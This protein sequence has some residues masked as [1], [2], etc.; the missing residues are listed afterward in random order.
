LIHSRNRPKTSDLCT[1]SGARQVRLDDPKFFDGMAGP[2]GPLARRME[3]SRAA[4]L[5]TED[6][7]K[8]L[9]L[10]GLALKAQSQAS[11]EVL[12]EGD[13]PEKTLELAL[14][15]LEYADTVFETS[16]AVDAAPLA[17]R[18]GCSWC[19]HVYVESKI[20]EVLAV[21]LAV[22]NDF[23]DEDRAA[24]RGRIEQHVKEAEGLSNEDLVGRLRHPCPLLVD[25]A[26][27]VYESRP[28]AC[29][30]WHSFDAAACKSDVEAPRSGHTMKVNGLTLALCSSLTNGCAIALKTARLDHRTVDF[31]R[32]LKAV[33][34]DPS[35]VETWRTRPGAFD[36]AVSSRCHPGGP[37][38]SG[39]NDRSFKQAY[40]EVT[41]SPEW[42]Q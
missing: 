40:R 41:N 18:K 5:T 31:V 24:L 9:E 30:S 33:L 1:V 38:A 20:P 27:S 19:C 26:C 11:R 17:C 2:V 13:T 23:S 39:M 14:N 34:D 6:K 22:L 8:F 12:N 29:R 35:L 25:G 28:L 7:R 42:N 16:R 32:A 37:W 36:A 10:P 4:E 15:V 3:M 21:A